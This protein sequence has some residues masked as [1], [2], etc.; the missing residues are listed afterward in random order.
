VGQVPKPHAKQTIWWTAP[1]PPTEKKVLVSFS[2]FLCRNNVMWATSFTFPSTPWTSHSMAQTSVWVVNQYW[3]S[4][5]LKGA[6]NTFLFFGLPC[7][8]VKLH[9][10]HLQGVRDVCNEC[11]VETCVP[12]KI[13]CN[14]I[15]KLFTHYITTTTTTHNPPL[16]LSLQPPPPPSGSSSKLSP[17]SD[18]SVLF[19][20]SL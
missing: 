13:N 7:I 14:E 4:Y 1:R 9:S 15:M 16:P 6:Y 3:C 8:F 19:T 5:P 18:V 12:L 20:H 10:T 2:F 17:H 11:T